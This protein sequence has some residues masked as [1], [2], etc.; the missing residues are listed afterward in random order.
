ME[1]PVIQFVDDHTFFRLP[2]LQV[3]LKS[4][5]PMD[6]EHRTLVCKR[7]REAIESC[8]CRVEDVSPV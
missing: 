5:G 3:E 1:L 6:P 2:Q 4:D 7:I 8:G